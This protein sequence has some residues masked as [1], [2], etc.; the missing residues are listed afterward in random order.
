M[1]G[2]VLVNQWRLWLSRSALHKCIAIEI[3]SAIPFCNTVNP[4]V[5]Q[6]C[7]N[8]GAGE[9]ARR[10]ALPETICNHTFRGTGI[11]V[12][13]QNGGSLEAAQDLANH[14][15]PRTTKLYDRRKDLATLS[16]IEILGCILVVCCTMFRT[17]RGTDSSRN[18]VLRGECVRESARSC[19]AK[20][21]F[22][23]WHGSGW[24]RKT[25][26]Y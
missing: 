2:A 5:K 13:L 26:K 12:F 3:D 23:L 21:I 16:E 14:S 20:P 22:R 15:D 17:R 6:R 11:T 9:F 19:W 10:R 7:A 4:A 25:P 18:A 1:G 24:R 8:A